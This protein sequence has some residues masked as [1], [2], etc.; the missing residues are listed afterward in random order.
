MFLPIAF[1]NHQER[2]LNFDQNLNKNFYNDLKAMYENMSEDAHKDPKK[3]E[4]FNKNIAS[5]QNANYLLESSASN[6][7]DKNKN[8]FS[9]YNNSQ[10]KNKKENGV[11]KQEPAESSKQTEQ[12]LNTPLDYVLS[13]L[14]AIAN[15]TFMQ[16]T[17]PTKPAQIVAS[18]SA[19]TSPSRSP[20]FLNE[21]VS[22]FSQEN[23]DDSS[24]AKSYDYLRKKALEYELNAN[25]NI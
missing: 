17:S 2:L 1:A 11:S 10:F 19:S 6:N 16:Q 5:Y 18:S 4:L 14:A 13:N 12:K 7:L 21:T 23:F 22:K 24:K 20:N 25:E 8:L 3:L 9:M 15:G